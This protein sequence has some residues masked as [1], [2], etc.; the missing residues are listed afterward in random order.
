VAAAT[1][2]TVGFGVYPSLLLDPMRGAAIPMITVGADRRHSTGAVSD[3]AMRRAAEER[4]RELR[5]RYT[6]EP[7]DPETARKINE[8]NLRKQ[9]EDMKRLQGV[10][11][12]AGG[13][14]PVPKKGA[15]AGSAQAGRPARKAGSGTEPSKDLRPA[16]RGLPPGHPPID[17]SGRAGNR[18]DTPKGSSS[19]QETRKSDGDR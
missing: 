12:P 8:E 11:S 14:A 9:R 10:G 4:I 18:S 19:S 6:T 16:A 13:G 1:V 5:K 7:V 3:A 2:V 17:G 15:G